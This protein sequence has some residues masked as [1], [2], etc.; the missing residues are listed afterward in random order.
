MDEFQR[1]QAHRPVPLRRSRGIS[2]IA[3][4]FGAIVVGLV[5]L[6]VLRVL[7]TVNEYY[8]I[9]RTINKLAESGGATVADIRAGFDRQ[10]GIEY[11]IQSISGK[12][13]DI[14]KQDDRVVI[15]FDYDKEVELRDPVCLLIKYKVRSK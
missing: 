5:A 11:S 4:L 9:R 14:R 13:L 8:T 10:K 15:A 7:P 3:L 6:V 1:S 2:L 12:D